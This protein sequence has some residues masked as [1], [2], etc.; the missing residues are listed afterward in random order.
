MRRKRWFIVILFGV[1]EKY[2]R[3]EG[4]IGEGEVGVVFWG[5]LMRD[6]FGIGYKGEIEGV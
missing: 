6:G 4:K 5:E 3:C 1:C 2:L